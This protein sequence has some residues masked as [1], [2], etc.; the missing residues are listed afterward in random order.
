MAAEERPLQTVS[1]ANACTVP[2]QLAR[3]YRETTLHLGTREKLQKVLNWLGKPRFSELPIKFVLLN[4]HLSLRL[5]K[6]PTP[7]PFPK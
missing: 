1:E 2:M 7:T 5:R 4:C 3:I 6:V